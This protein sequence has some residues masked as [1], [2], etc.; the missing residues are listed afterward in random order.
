M[1]ENL[2]QAGLLSWKRLEAVG[3]KHPKRCQTA[4]ACDKSLEQELQRRQ[5]E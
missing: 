3:I 4:A 2:Y 1:A 5:D